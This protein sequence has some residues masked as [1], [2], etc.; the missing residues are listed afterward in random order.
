LIF[1]FFFAADF[2]LIASRC[3]CRGGVFAA[4]RFIFRRWLIFRAYFCC[5]ALLMLTPAADA[6]SFSSLLP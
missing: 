5:R 3:R 2:S 1:I 6:V 4:R